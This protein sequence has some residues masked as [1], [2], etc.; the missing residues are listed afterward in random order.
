VYPSWFDEIQ[1]HKQFKCVY[2]PSTCVPTR[3]HSFSNG[4]YI[5]NSIAKI[6]GSGFGFP[7]GQ[8]NEMVKNVIKG[9]L[10]HCSE[11]LACFRMFKLLND[12]LVPWR[13]NHR[14]KHLKDHLQTLVYYPKVCSCTNKETVLKRHV[15]G[16]KI[17]I[18]K[19]LD[20]QSSSYLSWS[21]DN[22]CPD[23]LNRI[24]TC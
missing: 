21:H 4:V 20:N 1:L 17:P 7:V 19:G 16:C 23:F 10:V 9:E 15:R 5:C 13:L 2:T 3:V 24:T 8:D 22:T 12:V 14:Q 6:V 11:F 18:S